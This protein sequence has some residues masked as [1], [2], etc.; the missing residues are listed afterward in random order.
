MFRKSIVAS[1]LLL[2]AC[3]RSNEP[4]KLVL[5]V[6][7]LELTVPAGQQWRVG[8]TDGGKDE[9][10]LFESGKRVGS[11]E[12]ELRPQDPPMDAACLA[13]LTAWRDDLEKGGKPVRTASRPAYLPANWTQDVVEL[14]PPSTMPAFYGFACTMFPKSVVWV[15]VVGEDR[16]ADALK[17]MLQEIARAGHALPLPAKTLE[18]FTSIHIGSLGLDAQLHRHDVDWA[19]TD[20]PTK[21]GGNVTILRR[22]R[23]GEPERSL[24]IVKLDKKCSEVKSDLAPSK[25]RPA[26][27][28]A[29]WAPSTE[30]IK[31]DELTFDF[32]YDFAGACALVSTQAPMA[33]YEADTQFTKDVRDA[34]ETI[35]RALAAKR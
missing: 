34:L 5:P 13:Y 27:L 25:R 30:E 22:D 15:E 1:L 28:P 6:S 31:G 11:V 24:F 4:A 21:D 33:D 7:Q 12:L 2:A 16:F 19:A 32:T 9:L 35:T 10:S 18:Q 29:G 26:F 17:T 8:R 14:V 20:V 3:F 23:E